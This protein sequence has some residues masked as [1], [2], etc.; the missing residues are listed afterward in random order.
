MIIDSDSVPSREN[1]NYPLAFQ[2][3]VKGRIKKKLSNAAG[4]NNFGVNLVSLD[5]GSSSALRH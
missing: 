4:L 1:S 3:V 5:P 2:A